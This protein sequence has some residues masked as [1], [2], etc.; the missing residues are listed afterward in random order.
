MEQ[1][2]RRLTCTSRLAL[3][4][5]DAVAHP[6]GKMGFGL[7]RYGVAPTVVVIDRAQAGGDLRALTGIPCDAS[8]VASVR[9]ALTYG[10]DTLVPATVTVTP[11]ALKPREPVRAGLDAPETIPTMVAPALAGVGAGVAVADGAP[12]GAVR[13]P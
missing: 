12:L 1:Q 2:H 6:S 13:E 3:L 4:M 7:M 8:I 10:P 5:H 11:E 9:E